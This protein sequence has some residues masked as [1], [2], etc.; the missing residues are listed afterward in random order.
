MGRNRKPAKSVT[1]APEVRQQPDWFPYDNTTYYNPALLPVEIQEMIK[2]GGERELARYETGYYFSKTGARQYYAAFGLDPENPKDHQ[3]WADLMSI[4]DPP[5]GVDAERLID[6]DRGSINLENYR[7]V[8]DD[9]ITPE[10]T[11]YAMIAR[12][13]AAA[14]EIAKRTGKQVRI[15]TRAANGGG[16]SGFSVWPKLGYNFN[17]P[18]SVQTILE[19]QYGFAPDQVYQGTAH[20][21]LQRNAAGQLGFDVWRSAT[22]NYADAMHNL[23]ETFIYPDGQETPATRITR[24][25]GKRKGFVKSLRQNTGLLGAEGISAE[26]DAILRDIWMG[27]SRGT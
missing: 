24:E 15:K 11:G 25:Y 9:N 4:F 23:G 14:Q 12:Q 1:A 17:I 16:W 19:N 13:V 2:G 5:N 27:M 18:R 3:I 6:V 21:M 8:T 10:G 26:D 20:F 22:K 7:I